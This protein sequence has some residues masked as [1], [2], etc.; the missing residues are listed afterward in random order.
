MGHGAWGIGH[1]A[2]VVILFPVASESYRGHGSAVS[3]P[4]LIVGTR[5]CRVLTVSNINS[6]ATGVDI[7]RNQ[8]TTRCRSPK[9]NRAMIT[10][11]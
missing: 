9:I 6:D 3:L 10:S 7:S 8:D 11:Q 1:W 4:P 2:L 5:H